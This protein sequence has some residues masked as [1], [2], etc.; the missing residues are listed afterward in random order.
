MGLGAEAL[1]FSYLVL[2]RG[3]VYVS[4]VMGGE[5]RCKYDSLDLSPNILSSELN[6][7]RFRP[8]PGYRRVCALLRKSILSIVVN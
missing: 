2:A 3:M 6:L 4:R 5:V 1:V 7:G 8:L